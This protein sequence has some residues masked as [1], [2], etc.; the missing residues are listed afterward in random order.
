MYGLFL[1]VLCPLGA[2]QFRLEPGFYTGSITSHFH[3]SA[4][5]FLVTSADDRTP[6][7]K[8][9]SGSRRITA[10]TGK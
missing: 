2:R 7:R 8:V 1:L 5:R 9:C 4:E 6:E 10:K 3:D